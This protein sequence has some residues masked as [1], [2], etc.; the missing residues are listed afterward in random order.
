MRR[1]V[2]KEFQI[3]TADYARGSPLPS[4]ITS[5]RVKVN[6][7]RPET[8]VVSVIG[9]DFLLPIR[10]HEH[11]TIH[12]GSGEASLIGVQT[13]GFQGNGSLGLDAR[14]GRIATNLH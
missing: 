14:L 11:F 5:L 7:V 10:H 6:I 9:P 4:S 8:L 2:W 13:G 1:M 12:R 3:T